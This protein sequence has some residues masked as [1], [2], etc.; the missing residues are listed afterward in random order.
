M[1]HLAP[2]RLNALCV[3]KLIRYLQDVPCT[4]HDVAEYTGLAVSTSRRF[5]LALER[6]GAI[7]VVGWEQDSL[8]RF[9]T[10]VFA[11]GQGKSVPRPKPVKSLVQ[12]RK[13]RYQRDKLNKPLLLLAA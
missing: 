11:F 7:H 10:K 8:S 6:E 12:R 4:I 13:E 9:T 2:L 5:I 3:A 1:R